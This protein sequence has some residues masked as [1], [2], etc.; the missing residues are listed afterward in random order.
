MGLLGMYSSA[1]LGDTAIQAVVLAALRKRRPDIEF[2]GVSHDPDDVART[3]G[4]P[5]FPASGCGVMAF[6]EGEGCAACSTGARAVK[7]ASQATLLRRILAL[8]NVD[9]LVKSLDMLIVSGGGQIEDFWGGAWQQPLRLLS[10]CASAR[11]RGKPTAGFALGVDELRTRL[12]IFFSIRALN[13]M[14]YLSFRDAGSLQFLNRE[15]L[16][17]AA[18][19]CPDPAF[20]YAVPAPIE[21]EASAGRFAVISPMSVDAFPA[22]STAHYDT[23]LTRLAA[24]ADG[25]LRQGIAVRFACSQTSMD[26]RVVLRVMSRMASADQAI[27][28]EVRTV[29]D[30]LR[31]VHGAELV[32]T[33]RLHGTILSL[34]VHAP[35]IAV[36]NA[37]KTARLMSDLSLQDYCLGVKDLQEDTLQSRV[38]EVIAGSRHLSGQIADRLVE[39]RQQLEFAFDDLARAVP[40]L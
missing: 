1:N 21:R 38:Q 29:D 27:N 34:A 40:V 6:P 35:V 24:A 18:A 4:I 9:R 17:A 16:S 36:S 12:G 30:F 15:G 14:R 19:V 32:I 39:L 26:P 22:M 23:Y 2:I 37:R 11:L 20:G 33:S 31:T 10:W 28:V 3:Y 13:T 7:D 5:G 8:P 25:L